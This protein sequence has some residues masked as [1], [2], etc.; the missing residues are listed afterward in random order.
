[1]NN[2][3]QKGNAGPFDL[4]SADEAARLAAEIEE[5]V[6]RVPGLRR[7]DRT[8][9]RRA[10]YWRDLGKTHAW[11]KSVHCHV[12]VARE[13][14]TNPNIVRRVVTLLGTRQVGLWGVELVQQES[15]GMHR[16][17][18]DHECESH[19]LTVWLAL[20]GAGPASGLKVID[21]SHQIEATPQ[22]FKVSDNLVLTDDEAV[23]HAA[24]TVVPRAALSRPLVFPGQFVI[25]AGTLWH[26]SF[27]ATTI[28]R[29]SLVMQYS[30]AGALVRIPTKFEPPLEWH[31][32]RP[33]VLAVTEA[34]EPGP[35]VA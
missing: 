1:M 19:G 6:R 15:G 25:M 20:T 7:E 5:Q 17:H 3:A 27:N 22:H 18:V 14:A 34:P 2:F 12:H 35:G 24:R 29:K 13:L 33:P 31:A 28:P 30:P 10:D 4:L 26:A 21:R 8:G 9:P 32:M 16:W 23:L 11:Y